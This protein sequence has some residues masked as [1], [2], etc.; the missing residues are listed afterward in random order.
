MVKHSI[1]AAPGVCVGI[2]GRSALV[3]SASSEHLPCLPSGVSVGGDSRGKIGA[4]EGN[5]TFVSCD[6]PG[7]P[8]KANAAE[9]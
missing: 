3:D 5:V 8:S 1:S 6:R 2:G 9:L 4:R 7:I